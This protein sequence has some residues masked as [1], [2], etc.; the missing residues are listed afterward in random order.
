MFGAYKIIDTRV[1]RDQKSEMK[2]Q[3]TPPQH[4]HQPGALIHK[5]TDDRTMASFA[6]AHDDFDGEEEDSPRGQEVMVL[7]SMYEE[8]MDRNE[9][10]GERSIEEGNETYTST[11]LESDRN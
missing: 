8:E 10:Y 2:L 9:E 3:D 7:Q 6:K 4:H 11:T 5:A 1:F